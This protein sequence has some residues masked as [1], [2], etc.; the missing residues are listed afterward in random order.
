MSKID[1][2]RQARQTTRR[3]RRPP[4]EP[5]CIT[6]SFAEGAAFPSERRSGPIEL[7]VEATDDHGR[8]APWL[9]DVWWMEVLRRWRDDT[10]TIHIEPAPG[11]L[12]HPVTLHHM[13]MAARVA[14]RWRLIGHLYSGDL[15]TD[16]QIR[17]IAM[18][19][20]HEVRFIDDL[21]PDAPPEH[22]RLGVLPIEGL[23]GRIRREQVRI[24]ANR[25]ILVRVP[26]HAASEPGI[27]L[28]PSEL[29]L[30]PAASAG[31]MART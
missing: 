7:R 8:I 11:A 3:T 27:N 31:H 16:E 28:A 25:P 6:A 24:S 13:E 17:A 2:I 14:P 30:E 10:V 26:P 29:G 4:S 20:Y 9:D 12:L 18:S 22:R 21:R 23:F 15:T 1:D 5:L 19:P